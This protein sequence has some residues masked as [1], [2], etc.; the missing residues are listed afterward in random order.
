MLVNVSWFLGHGDGIYLYFNFSTTAAFE[1]G[2]VYKRCELL[3]EGALVWWVAQRPASR[4]SKVRSQGGAY[5]PGRSLN[6]PLLQ[7]HLKQNV[8]DQVVQSF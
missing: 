3:P 2:K 5:F 7:Q 8:C 4:R 1:P 6:T